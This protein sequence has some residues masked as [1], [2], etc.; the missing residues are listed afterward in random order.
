MTKKTTDPFNFDLIPAGSRVLCAL[1]GG[2]DSMYLL[3][4]L[5]EHDCTVHAAHF[6]HRLRADAGRDEQFVRDWCAARSIPLT[7]GDGDVAAHARA[8]GA[9]IEEA[10]RELRY[11][12]L[13]KAAA[14]TGCTLI[15]TGHHAGDN[16]E[17]VLMNLI[18]GCGLNGL[19]GIPE[20][21]DNVIRP[22][23]AVE[24]RDIRAY[25]TA[26]SIPH[27][28]DESNR[29]TDYTR[30]RIRHQLL[31][32]LEELNPRAAAHIAAAAQ[33]LREDEAELQR[34][35]KNLLNN[36]TEGEDGT[37]I[38]AALL[39]GAPRPVALRALKALAPGAQAVHL[40]ALLELC[41]SEDPSA[42]L[43]LPGV[44]ARRVYG[45]LL[46]S[47][48]AAPAPPP[49]PLAE[50][51]THWGQW[52]ITRTPAVCPQKAYLSP[53][54][55]YLK[56]DDYLIRSR[57]AGD[58]LKLGPRPQKTVKNLMMEARIPRHL[59]ELVPLLADST[60]RAAAA[61]GLGPHSGALAAPGSRCFRITMKKGE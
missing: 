47:A 12:F 48:P 16:A 39:A 33:R 5:A 21:R 44:T 28:E 61:G 54:E 52:R 24:D 37:G 59:R 13:R 55:F 29:D 27:V 60:G 32:L 34:Q 49:A 30:N 51:E 22:M 15:A 57:A 53:E 17:T 50:G 36:C 45:D 2:A 11:R 25:L 1:S 31:P 8:T 38:S 56:P 4:R 40:E 23:L 43:D 42:R 46:F 26:R 6:N 3:C 19:C 20:R 10:A 58:E 35:A 7:V 18:R 41:R 14:E 9:G